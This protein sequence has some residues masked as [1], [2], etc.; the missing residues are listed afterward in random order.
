MFF[1]S[2]YFFKSG[3]YLVLKEVWGSIAFYQPW[4]RLP[5]GDNIALAVSDSFWRCLCPPC[6]AQEAWDRT[7]NS[8]LQFG[9]LNTLL[10]PLPDPAMLNPVQD[11]R[12][13]QQTASRFVCTTRVY[14]ERLQSLLW[15]NLLSWSFSCLFPWME[16]VSANQPTS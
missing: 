15:S 3:S 2:Y 6:T 8:T 1:L 13:L 5:G 14:G 9:H 10:S 7:A 4:R 12:S 11:L 16:L